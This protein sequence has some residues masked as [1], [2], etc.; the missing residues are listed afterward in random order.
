MYVYVH[1]YVY[2]NVHAF[3]K[4]CHGVRWGRLKHDVVA[5]E[6]HQKLSERSKPS[7]QQKGR[8]ETRLRQAVQCYHPPQQGCSNAIVFQSKPRKTCCFEKSPAA[9]IIPLPAVPLCCSWGRALLQ[10]KL[11]R[12]VNADVNAWVL[13]SALN[14]TNRCDTIFVILATRTNDVSD[15]NPAL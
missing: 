3:S 13:V 14:I 2:T 15:F 4:V 9:S 10:R 1:I 6:W 8:K 12:R 5:P 7:Q 11:L